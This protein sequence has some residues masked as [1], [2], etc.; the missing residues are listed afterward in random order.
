R[1]VRHQRGPDSYQPR[2]LR[3]AARQDGGQRRRDQRQARHG[4]DG[5]G[6]EGHPQLRRRLVDRRGDRQGHAQRAG[7]QQGRDLRQ[8]RTGHQDRQ[9]GRRRAVG[10]GQQQR[11]HPGAHHG[12]AQGRRRDGEDRQDQAAGRGRRNQCIGHTRRLGAQRR[13]R[14]LH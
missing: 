1:S 8:R 12:R 3:R 4:G 7:G 6:R 5:L 13:R 9:G 10:G 11:H 14:R 2:W